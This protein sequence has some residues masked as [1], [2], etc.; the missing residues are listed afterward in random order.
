MGWG[1]IEFFFEEKAT[2]LMFSSPTKKIKLM[3]FDQ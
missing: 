2:Y 1:F 3:R